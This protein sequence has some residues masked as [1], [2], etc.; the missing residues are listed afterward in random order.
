MLLIVGRTCTGK[1]TLAR[2]LEKYGMKSVVSYTTR[3]YN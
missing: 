1:D 2:E 3:L